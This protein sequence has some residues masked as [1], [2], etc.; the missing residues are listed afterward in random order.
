MKLPSRHTVGGWT[1]EMYTMPFGRYKGEHL[2]T[3]PDS[4]IVWLKDNVALREPLLSAIWSQMKARGLDLGQRPA[5][6]GGV[7]LATISGI[8]RRLSNEMHPDRGGNHWAQVA[9]NRFYDEIKGVVK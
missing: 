8:Y 3:V 4:Y 1:H 7:D 9:L 6:G 2:D 5:G